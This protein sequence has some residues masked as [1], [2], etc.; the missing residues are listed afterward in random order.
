[1]ELE[2]HTTQVSQSLIGTCATDA[3]RMEQILL[4]LPMLLGVEA[5]VGVE[6]G[7]G[8]GSIVKVIS[9]NGQAEHMGR[10]STL[11]PRRT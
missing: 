7:Q 1:M 2:A 6:S 10:L 3:T 9:L 8:D 5:K 4:A 11:L